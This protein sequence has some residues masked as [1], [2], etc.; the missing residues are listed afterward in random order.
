MGIP[1]GIKTWAPRVGALLATGLFLA[2]GLMLTD[3][4]RD[5]GDVVLPMPSPGNAIAQ[6]KS[7][8]DLRFDAWLPRGIAFSEPREVPF[9]K[10]RAFFAAGPSKRSPDE[11]FAEILTQ[12]RTEMDAAAQERVRAAGPSAQVALRMQHTMGTFPN[13]A[14]LLRLPPDLEAAAQ[15]RLAL[16]AGGLLMACGQG[17][18]WEYITFYFPRGLDIEGFVRSFQ[19]RGNPLVVLGRDAA[20]SLEPTLTIDPAGAGVIPELK[21]P[22]TVFCRARGRAGDAIDHAARA[23]ERAGWQTLRQQ[24]GGPG[25]ESRVLSGPR[26]EVWFGTSDRSV[27]GGLVT[28]MIS[29]P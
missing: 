4:L 24:G 22:A 19:P 3:W 10:N 16:E 13:G 9:G 6:R 14:F 27:R 18:R 28:V 1:V 11:V 20:S 23:M 25:E 21:A 12:A 15:G 7:P 26:G 5:R 8:D 2:A 29:A 17:N